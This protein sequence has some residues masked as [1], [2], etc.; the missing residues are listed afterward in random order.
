MN[1]LMNGLHFRSPEKYPPVSP[2]LTGE[3]SGAKVMSLQTS[4]YTI[5]ILETILIV[6][7]NKRAWSR[8]FH[9]DLI[10]LNTRHRFE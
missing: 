7:P 9:V 3:A 10:V 1:Y 5:V 6:P 2:D 4:G 8:E